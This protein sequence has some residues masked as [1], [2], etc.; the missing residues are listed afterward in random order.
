MYGE[1]DVERGVR[2]REHADGARHARERLDDLKVREVL[3]EHLPEPVFVNG[4]C[5]W[6]FI[7]EW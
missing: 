5:R 3:L 6:S 1:R 2:E 7:P 4:F